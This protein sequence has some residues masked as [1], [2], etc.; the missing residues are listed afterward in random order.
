MSSYVLFLLLHGS[1]EFVDNSTNSAE[2]PE[3]HKH[4]LWG[5]LVGG[6]D[7][8]DNHIDST[9][10]YIYNEVAIDYNAGVVG[11]LAGHY[12]YYK[13][14]DMPIKNFPP[15]EPKIDEYFSEAK[16]E[17]ENNQRSQITI[18]VHNVSVHPPR[19]INHIK[20]RYFFDISELIEKRQSI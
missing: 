12:M 7:S 2:E 18:D 9:T 6:P 8:S 5:A 16:V 20:A 13:Q 15:K 10:D 1:I 11:A 17:Q 19:M 4:I 14:D 3:K